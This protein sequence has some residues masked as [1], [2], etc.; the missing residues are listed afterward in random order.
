MAVQLP[1][2]WKDILELSE[3]RIRAGDAA[4]SI[5]VLEQI[6]TKKIPRE[7][8]LPLANH[9]RR[10]GLVGLGL[11]VLSPLV[12]PSEMDIHHQATP[13]ELAEYAVLI[14]RYGAAQE[15]L[16]ILNTIEPQDVPEAP[17]FK[18]YC[19]FNLWQYEE[20]I[21][22]LRQFIESPSNLYMGFVGKVNLAAALIETHRLDEAAELVRNNIEFARTNNYLR[23]LGNNYELL[24]KVLLLSKKF[25]EAEKCLYEANRVFASAQTHDQLYVKGLQAWLTAERLYSD[26]PLK[27][28]RKEAFLRGEPESAREADL[29]ALSIKFS[30]PDFNFLYFGTPFKAFRNVIVQRTGSSPIQESYILGQQ[31]VPCLDIKS[32]IVLGK[33]H[34]TRSSQFE[35][36]SHGSKAHKLLELLFRDFYRPMNMGQLFSNLF[37]D[38][39]FDIF[40]SPHRI[41]QVVYR[42][43]LFLS[44]NKIPISIFCNDGKFSAQCGDKISILVPKNREP[45]NRGNQ[46]LELLLSTFAPDEEFSA[47]QIMKK[48]G[49][50]KSSCQR[51]IAKAIEDGDL[52]KFGAGSNTRYF[53]PKKVA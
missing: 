33:D 17:L 3:S 35:P 12:R 49:I 43:R 51:F 7:F 29:N 28:F 42:T 8:R 10:T 13:N 47:T 22:F 37:P 50:T 40:T 6:N 23:L 27:E 52:E 11:R 44:E 4:A 53:V 9:C 2:E 20:S 45:V 14:Q 18:A 15:A 46:H 48:L 39:Y 19:H 31:G 32:G 34:K 1:S 25:D 30:E 5:K 24:A 36:V 26:V 16:G 41:E 21:P 38:E